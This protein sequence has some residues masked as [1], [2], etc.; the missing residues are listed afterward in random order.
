MVVISFLMYIL[1]RWSP[2]SYQNNREKF[3]DDD[4]KREFNMKECLVGFFLNKIYKFLFF[5]SFINNY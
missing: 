3:K 2:F 4:E 1:D 5:N